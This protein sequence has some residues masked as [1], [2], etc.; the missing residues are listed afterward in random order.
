MAH[1]QPLTTWTV[2][3]LGVA[4]QEYYEIVELRIPQKESRCELV[5][6]DTLEQ[7]VDALARKLVEVTSAI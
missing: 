2:E 7:K 5:A 4:P 1:R 3:E 6:G